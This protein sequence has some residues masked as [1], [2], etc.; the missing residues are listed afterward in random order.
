MSSRPQYPYVPKM[1]FRNMFIIIMH[2]I[3]LNITDDT[4][5]V[6]WDLHVGFYDSKIFFYKILYVLIDACVAALPYM[7]T[8]GSG[9]EGTGL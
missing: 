6:I 2:A 8:G 5:G 3:K 9:N 1:I 4:I 7:R